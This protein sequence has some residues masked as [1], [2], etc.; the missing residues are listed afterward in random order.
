LV[1]QFAPDILVTQLGVD[2][3]YRDPLT[4]MMLTTHGYVAV[5]GELGMLAS[6]IGSWLALGGGGY[7]VDVV[8]RAWTMA[9]G[10]MSG[11]SF[12]D[13]LPDTY[14][15]QYGTGSLH[16]AQ[17]PVLHEGTVQ[18]TRTFAEWVVAA[19]EKQT[20]EVWGSL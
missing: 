19:L 17:V 13:E 1:R 16:D 5:V 7:A 10:V 9:Y 11:Q 8:P 18:D 14:V 20:C 3:H 15:A 6:E 4:E 12:A 2:T